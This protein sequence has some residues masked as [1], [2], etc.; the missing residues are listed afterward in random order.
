MRPSKHHPVDYCR[1]ATHRHDNRLPISPAVFNYDRWT[2]QQLH[3]RACTAVVSRTGSLRCMVFQL[4]QR[5]DTGEAAGSTDRYLLTTV[6]KASAGSRV[7]LP[8]TLV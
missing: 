6:T 8:Q 2:R 1:R 3:A 7:C 5:S 4:S